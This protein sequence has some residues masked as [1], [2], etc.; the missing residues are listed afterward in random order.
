M[1]E[2]TSLWNPWLERM[3]SVRPRPSASAWRL[4]AA[5]ARHTFGYRR[6][7][8]HLGIDL[9]RRESGLDGRSF[10]RARDELVGL[11]LLEVEPGRPGRGN[12]TRWQL[13]RESSA[14]ERRIEQEDY[15][16]TPVQTHAR[17][18]VQTP[19][20]TTAPE[21][22]RITDDER[23][24][25][26]SSAND[27][28]FERLGLTDKQKHEA[29]QTDPNVVREWLLRSEARDVENPAA[30]FISGIRSRRS[31]TPPGG[32]N[33]LAR[34]F[35]ERHG[36]PT[37]SRWVRGEVSGKYVPDPLG[38]DVPPHPVDWRTPSIPKIQAALEARLPS[39]DAT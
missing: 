28:A 34:R 21:R 3:L 37:G 33:A 4:A 18:S 6:L 32:P 20:E 19:A 38:Y 16:E 1:A 30:F 24:T 17:A 10:S 36:R 5:I 15:D 12:R 25:T 9:L 2:R 35:V 29:R 27:A 8:E 26:T 11:G 31:P 39:K 13:V 22:T 7:E 14:P 23:E